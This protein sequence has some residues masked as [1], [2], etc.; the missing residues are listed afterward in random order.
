MNLAEFSRV[1]SSIHFAKKG[2]GY[3]NAKLLHGLQNLIQGCVQR[4]VR[5][6][7]SVYALLLPLHLK[8]LQLRNDVNQAFYQKQDM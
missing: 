4:I 6:H 1:G 3:F 5:V 8:H 2:C 7:A